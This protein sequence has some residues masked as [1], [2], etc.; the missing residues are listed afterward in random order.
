MCVSMLMSRSGTEMIARFLKKVLIE[1]L[2]AN[3]VLTVGP[4]H[5]HTD[6]N[7]RAVGTRSCPVTNLVEKLIDSCTRLG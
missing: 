4:I 7:H 2:E 6:T 1:N 5:T 3:G